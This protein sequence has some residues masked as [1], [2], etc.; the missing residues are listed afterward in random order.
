MRISY[1][2]EV[3]AMYIELIEGERECRVV[4]L[5][6]DISLNMGVGEVLVGIEILNASALLGIFNTRAKNHSKFMD[7]IKM[8]NSDSHRISE[9]GK[10]WTEI[11]ESKNVEGVL[12][13]LLGGHARGARIG[14][15]RKSI[16]FVRRK[17]GKM[18]D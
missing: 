4:Q 16:R 9:F 10:A 5:T 1:D 13:N 18:S 11:K 14:W 7:F 17:L 15:S 2:E 6:D 3:D 8:G 12:H